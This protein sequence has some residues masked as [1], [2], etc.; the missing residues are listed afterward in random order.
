M[1][2]NLPGHALP[3]L[4]LEIAASA[5]ADAMRFSVRSPVI[6]GMHITDDAAP[7]LQCTQ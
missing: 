1:F 3:T 4:P 6:P 5:H 7:R 2:R